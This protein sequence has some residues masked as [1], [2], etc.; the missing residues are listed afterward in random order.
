MADSRAVL[1]SGA[2]TGIGRATALRL[3]RA[4]WRV[5]AGVRKESDGASL[6]ADGSARLRPVT[7]DVT[8][9]HTIDGV[10]QELQGALGDQGLAGL[11]NNAGIGL[12]GPVEFLSLDTYREVMEVNYFGHIAMTQKFLPM[13]RRGGGRVVFT[14]S[15]GGKISNAF[16][17]CYAG[18]KFALEAL[19]DALRLEVA[20]HGVKVSLIEPGAI[21]TPMLARVEETKDELLDAIP[22]EGVP[23]Y[24]DAARAALDGFIEFTKNAV[25]PDEVAK[26]IEHALTARRP[27]TR[28]LVGADAK[29][30]AFLA[31]ILS[32][33]A[34]DF[35]KRR[36]SA[37]K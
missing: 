13:V 14:G 30:N 33:R 21:R 34:L 2:S 23:L 17:S 8:Q 22:P 9:Q 24:R 16:M 25:D 1:I 20:P 29:L 35:A 3:D 18:T 10:H 27:K 5:F 4:G 26:A 15:V 28:Y 19:T 32:D 11:V 6:R 31:W 36:M 37:R 7:L 12:G